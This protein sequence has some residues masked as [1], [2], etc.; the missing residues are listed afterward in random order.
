MQ[1]PCGRCKVEVKDGDQA[2]QCEGHCSA[3]FHCS[4]GLELNLTN[5][6]YERLSLSQEKWICGNWCGDY[7]LPAF[8]SVD[9][10][11]VYHFWLPAKHAKHANRDYVHILHAIIAA[12]TQNQSGPPLLSAQRNPLP[13][14]RVSRG[15]S[16]CTRRYTWITASVAWESFNWGANKMSH[17]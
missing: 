12:T 3:W 1:Y 15:K 14:F 7:S 11:D 4:C 2:I 5:V 13:H 9:A 16:Q 17:S 10:L 8:N 6:Q